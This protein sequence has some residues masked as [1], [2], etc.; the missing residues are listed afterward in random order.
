MT[1][2]GQEL[3]DALAG[4]S[5]PSAIAMRVSPTANGSFA[6]HFNQQV[7]N[8]PAGDAPEAPATSGPSGPEL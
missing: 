2:K 4:A 8:P 1:M 3:Q 7:V 6:A 5:H